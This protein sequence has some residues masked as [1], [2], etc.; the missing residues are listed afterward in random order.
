MPW[1]V[2][3]P[4]AA[5]GEVAVVVLALIAA[6]ADVLGVL[7]LTRRHVP[8]LKLRI[9]ETV[10]AGAP[11]AAHGRLMSTAMHSTQGRAL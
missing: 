3:A 7:D 5:L 11:I 9:V 10:I 2:R 1:A 6:K 8:R 4:L